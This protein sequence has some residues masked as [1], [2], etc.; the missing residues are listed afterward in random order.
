M[1]N[2]IG[3][4][5]PSGSNKRFRSRFRADFRVRHETPEQGRRTYRPKHCEYNNKDEVSSPD[6][7]SNENN[8]LL[9]RVSFQVLQTRKKSL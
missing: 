1:V 6:I 3:T 4:I 8:N 5:Y 2:R 7:L 9:K